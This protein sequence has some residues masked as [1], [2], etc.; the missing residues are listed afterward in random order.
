M[1]PASSPKVRPRDTGDNEDEVKTNTEPPSTRSRTN[2]W[3]SDQKMDTLFVIPNYPPKC[4]HYDHRDFQNECVAS[5]QTKLKEHVPDAEK[6]DVHLVADV[7]CRKMVGETDEEKN[8]YSNSYAITARCA[9]WEW[10]WPDLFMTEV[11]AESKH[12]MIHVV[13]L[14]TWE[15]VDRKARVVFLGGAMMQAAFGFL[16]IWVS[17][18]LPESTRSSEAYATFMSEGLNKKAFV[19]SVTSA[20]VSAL[21]LGHH[22]VACDAFGTDSTD[23]DVSYPTNVWAM[24]GLCFYWNPTRFLGPVPQPWLVTKALL[25]GR[26]SPTLQDGTGT[27][28]ACTLGDRMDL[29]KWLD[30]PASLNAWGVWGERVGPDVSR[31]A[32]AVTSVLMTHVLWGRTMQHRVVECQFATSASVARAGMRYACPSVFVELCNSLMTTADT[33]PSIYPAILTMSLLL[34]VG[35]IPEVD[36]EFM[37]TWSTTPVGNISA[38]KDDIADI[39]GDVHDH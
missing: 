6:P 1:Y 38:A 9:D 37:M 22:T 14:G 29:V 15:G 19:Y 39:T 33:V 4:D 13:T 11:E 24:L 17:K 30:T 16:D 18:L 23:E 32:A 8:K 20:L 34:D 2:P 35:R 27:L 36:E 5:L 25:V 12:G 26:A 10:L 28:V 3:A 7:S 31:V 21:A